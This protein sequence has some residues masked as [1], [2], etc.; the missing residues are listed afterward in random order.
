MKYL[1]STCALALVIA[2]PATAK[3]KTNDGLTADERGITFEQGALEVNL[4]GRFHV[5]ASVY[6]DPANLQS[7]VSDVE[8][9][10][11][12][13]EMSGKVGDIFRFSV[14]REFAGNSKGWRN[15]WAGIE[16]V[17]NVEIR[18][19]NL[20]A[21]F[22]VEDMQSSNSM[23]F[24]ERSLASSLTP[25]YGLGG[26]VFANGKN[27]SASV[28]YFT[29]P[30]ANE[31]G[32]S[33]ER[34]DG[35]VGRL[36]AAPINSGNKVLHLALAGEKRTFAPTEVLRFSGDAGSAQAPR[37]MTS[38]A[39]TGL[40][41][42]T[43]YNAEV[44][45]TFGSLQILAMSTW[46][47][48]KRLTAADISFSGQTVQAAWL[49]T[50]GSYRYTEKG[51]VIGGPDLGRKKGAVEVAARYSRLDLE[52]ANVLRGTGRALSVGANW[53]I[54]RNVRVMAGYTNSQVT[55]SNGNAPVTNDVFVGRF[56]INF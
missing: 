15:V 20:I 47:N 36:T 12:R 14:S 2:N 52:D 1:L 22:S 10:R 54:N 51:G 16:P 8:I 26:A 17:K 34:G 5:D 18:G 33:P 29:D 21:P 23:P 35:V 41:N 30:L 45:G 7:D 50:G 56:Q 38:G 25:G 27:W 19:G 49:V 55:F 32:R 6:D 11:A 42:M 31:I 28:G 9:R 44:G 13:L 3:A 24:V 53:Y 43:A 48:I 46:T 4:G 39:L 40:D 37:L